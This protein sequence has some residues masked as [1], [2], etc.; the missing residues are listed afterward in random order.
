MRVAA[1]YDVHGNLPA[2]EAVLA[3]VAAEDVDND[4]L[5][6]ATSSAAPSRPRCSTGWRASG[7]P[8]RAR[9]RRPGGARRHGRVR[10]RLGA[11]SA[12][13]SVPERLAT[14]AVVAADE[15]ARGRRARAR[16]VLPRDAELGRRR[17]SRASPPTTTWSRLVGH[18]D[19]DVLVVRAH[20]RPVRPARS[21]RPSRRQRGERRH[22]VRGP[23]R[24]VLGAPRAGCRAAS[25]RVRRRDA[26]AALVAASGPR[27]P[28]THARASSLDPPDPDEATS[29]FESPRGA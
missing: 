25:H 15:R 11:W 8:L 26:A 24:G 21:D 23:A 3:D 17:S 20:P 9:E 14:V 4:R 6:A 10:H 12:R 5:S 13:G 16:A 7:R 22:A 29:F 2:L 27:A 18:T 1:L 28:T 19:A